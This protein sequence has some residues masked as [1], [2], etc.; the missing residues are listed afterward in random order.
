MP[1]RACDH[2]RANS[3]PR[4]RRAG[5]IAP[6]RYSQIGWLNSDCFRV[7]ATIFGSSA[8]PWNAASKVARRDAASVSLGPQ[9]LDEALEVRL[10]RRF[11]G[12]PRRL[13][14]LRGGFG[15]GRRSAGAPDGQKDGAPEP[16]C[17]ARSLNHR[18]RRHTRGRRFSLPSQSDKSM[19]NEA[20]PRAADASEVV[21]DL[22]RALPGERLG[23]DLVEVVEAGAPAEPLA[24]AVRLGHDRGRIARPARRQARP[25]SRRR[26]P[27]S[28]PRSPPAPS[29]PGRSRSSGSGF[30]RLRADGRA[31]P[32]ARWARSVTWM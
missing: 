7:S 20:V 25:R 23:D 16:A 28:P 27:A 24:D 22:E 1:S 2:S 13:S 26:T 6:S 18:S 11:G 9:R 30:R 4:A 8:T 12:L 29:S 14:R 5:E 21:A 19:V 31:R 15:H 10:F 3:L 17:R 32:G